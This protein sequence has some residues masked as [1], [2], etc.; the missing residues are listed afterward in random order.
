MSTEKK[1]ILPPVHPSALLFHDR[2]LGF[3]DSVELLSQT[4][5]AFRVSPF[6]RNQRTA[7]WT[8]ELE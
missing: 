5:D 7:T 6:A 3:Q 1:V 8:A 4:E 2:W